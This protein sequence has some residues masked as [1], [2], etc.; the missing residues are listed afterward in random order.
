M[1]RVEG[2][3]R[4]W[5]RDRNYRRE[6]EHEEFSECGDRK[7]RE[8]LNQSFTPM[9][10]NRGHVPNPDTQRRKWVRSGRWGWWEQ[11][12][13]ASDTWCE[14]GVRLW[15]FALQDWARPRWGQECAGTRDSV[16]KDQLP[17]GRKRNRRGSCLCHRDVQLHEARV[18]KIFIEW[19]HK[20]SYF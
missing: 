1:I 12:G 10:T 16:H 14:E 17:R 20:C 9:K 5:G 2:K 3:C 7:C 8:M 19:L 11:L 13:L 18:W 4:V 6:G 15:P